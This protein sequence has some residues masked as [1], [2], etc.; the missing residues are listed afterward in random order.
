MIKRMIFVWSV[1]ALALS[2]H[3]SEV[4]DLIAKWREH[5]VTNG[6]L[7]NGVAMHSDYY[8]ILCDRGPNIL[9]E[10]MAA[11]EAESD[12][13]VIYNYGGLIKQ[14]SGFET[15]VYTEESRVEYGLELKDTSKDKPVLSAKKDEIYGPLD[16]AATVQRDVYLRWWK[17]K[18]SF[19]GRSDTGAKMSLA[20]GKTSKEFASYDLKKYRSLSKDVLV[21][22]IYNIPAYVDAVGK[23]NNPVA[24]CEFLKVSRHQA[25]RDLPMTGEPPRNAQ[26]AQDAYPTREAKVELIRQWW[27]GAKD[28]YTN[29]PELRK[30]IDKSVAGIGNDVK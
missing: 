8:K 17:Q 29:L 18:D 15:Y 3:A 12:P 1:M 24:F 28:K 14:V 2:G 4:T 11:Y 10:L 25:Y 7:G 5:I 23:D 30:E 26:I 27:A 21:Y 20:T 22:G 13:Y 6:L 9:P 19:L 16:K